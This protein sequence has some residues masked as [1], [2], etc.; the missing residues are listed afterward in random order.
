MP[1]D[2]MYSFVCATPAISMAHPYLFRTYKVGD[3]MNPNC[4]IWEAARATT[5]AP[6]FFKRISIGEPGQA[7]TEFV[8]GALKC[9]NPTELVIGDARQLFGDT[10]RVGMVVS[11]GTGHR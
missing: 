5:A 6:T 7:K 9:N 1:I 2:V 3:L 10:Q 4:C 8:D 11:V